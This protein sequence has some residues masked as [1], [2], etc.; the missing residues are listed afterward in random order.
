MAFSKSRFTSSSVELRLPVAAS[1]SSSYHAQK[2]HLPQRPFL[3]GL[4]RVFPVTSGCLQCSSHAPVR[5][6]W[7]QPCCEPVKLMEENGESGKRKAEKG[8]SSFAGLRVDE[9]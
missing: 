8:R 9:I 7:K 6:G 5:R 1:S 4:Q 2:S 3:P